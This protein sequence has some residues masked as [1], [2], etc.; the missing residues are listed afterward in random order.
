MCRRRVSE[1]G[2]QRKEAGLV[3]RIGAQVNFPSLFIF[4]VFFSFLFSFYFQT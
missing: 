3:G 4:S 1:T 2:P